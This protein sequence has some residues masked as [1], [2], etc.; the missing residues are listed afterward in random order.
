MKNESMDINNPL[1]GLDLGLLN[2][3]DDGKKSTDSITESTRTQFEIRDMEAGITDTPPTEDGVTDTPPI[4]DADKADAKDE[5]KE[6][7]FNT[8]PSIGL[9]E[10][11]DVPEVIESDSG[12]ADMWSAFA[13]QGIINLEDDELEN[14]TPKDMDWF[15]SKAEAKIEEK[16]S[17]ALTEYKE[18]L[19]DELKYVLDHYD[20]GVHVMDLLKADKKIME[21]SSIDT[22]KLE[23]NEKMQKKIMT[24]YLTMQGETPEDIA[25]TIEDYEIGGL[26]EKNSK[27]ALGRLVKHQAKEKETMIATKKQEAITQREEYTKML[28]GLKSDIDKKE[29]IIPGIALSDKQKKQLYNGITKFDKSGKNEVMKFREANPE[30][31]LVV[32]YLATVMKTDDGAINW[33][34]LQEVAATKA[35]KDLKEKAV[36][37]DKRSYTKNNTKLSTVNLDIMKSALKF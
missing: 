2:I 10:V 23:E 9:K 33:N 15:A 22:D 37:G 4:E 30:F 6:I 26:L 25:E 5:G 31:D 27:K 28:T 35:S 16:V 18:S 32:A 36:K 7:D 34:K 12:A 3:G 20:E 14:D 17:D 21:Y 19:P 24:D 13:A 8:S 1:E 11:E 29:E